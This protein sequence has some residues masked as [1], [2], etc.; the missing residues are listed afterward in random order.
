[1]RDDRH[2]RHR[3]AEIDR[4][5]RPVDGFRTADRGRFAR[6]VEDV[7]AELPASFLTHLEETVILVEDVP[8][9][10]GAASTHGPD[11]VP[12]AR[13][14]AGAPTDPRGRTRTPARLILYRRPLE[15][16]ATSK[17][18]LSALVR[19]ITVLEVADH[20]GID[21]DAIDEQGWL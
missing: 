10:P 15:A 3:R 12:L 4:R 14:D 1:V 16:R 7:L 17:L 5:R 8:D 21:D 9:V 13:Y 19:E 6:L 18:E 20:L 11:E 2:A